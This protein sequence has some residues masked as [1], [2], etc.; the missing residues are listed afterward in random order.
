MS[1]T[2]IAG[3]EAIGPATSTIRRSS[4]R[5]F[6]TGATGWVGSAVV[7]ELIGAGHE[8]VGLARSEGAAAALVAAGAEA[9]RGDLGDPESLRSGAAGSDGVIHLAYNHDFSDMTGAAQTDLRAIET[10]GAALAGSG[11]PLVIASGVVLVGGDRLATEADTG[12]ASA[13][14]GHRV[15][16]AHATLDL[17]ERGVRSAVVRL[18]PSVHG[19]GDP[20]FVPAL[21]EIAR[22]SGVSGYVDRGA[23]RWPAV[24]RLDAA[25]L[26]RIA[27]E[28][29]PAGTVLHAI[30]EE[31][32][33]VREIAE[34]IGARLGLPVRSIAP[35]EAADHFGFLAGFLTLD[36]PTSSAVTRG[37]FGWEPVQPGL[38]A[39]IEQHYFEP[40]ELPLA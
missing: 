13:P 35:S 15:R 9:L 29:A 12:D 32:V 37:R 5:V 6:V 16:A 11:R 27:V 17:A 10:L 20:H 21:I 34:V 30:A 25:A 22:R 4:M 33:P 36:A 40:A 26:F 39:D 19:E 18:A 28:D 1:V 31:G 38:L 3:D 2:D 8:V 24:H 14:G 23:N 7:P